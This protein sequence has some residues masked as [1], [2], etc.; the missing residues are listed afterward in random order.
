MAVGSGAAGP[1]RRGG[2]IV[3]VPPRAA[4]WPALATGLAASATV[5]LTLTALGHGGPLALLGPAGYLGGAVIVAVRWPHRELGAA[6]RITLARLVLTSWVV[7]ALAP[8]ALADSWAV[9]V[10]LGIVVVGIA[11]LV[12]DGVDGRVARARGLDSPFGA[13]FDVE[14]D[15]ALILVLSLA[16]PLLGV[17]GWWVVGIGL[18]R[19]AYVAASLRRRWLRGPLF[20]SLARKVVGVLQV[21]ALLVTLVAALIPAVPGAAPR[22]VLGAALAA[23]CWSF[24]RDALWQWRQRLSRR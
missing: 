11:C 5:P 7:S 3:G 23:L 6:N 1:V 21:V 12:L 16:V 13:R 10:Q 20:P 24:G 8:A 2:A 15:A 14:V 22:V 19:Y 18:I 17:A 4:P 9:P